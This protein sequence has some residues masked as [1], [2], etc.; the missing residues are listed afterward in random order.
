ML[1]LKIEQDTANT[2]QTSSTDIVAKYGYVLTNNAKLGSGRYG[3]VCEAIHTKTQQKVAI[4]IIDTRKLKWEYRTKFLPREIQSW[5]RFRHPNLVALH[6]VF[7]VNGKIYMPMDLAERG[8]LLTYVQKYG[9]QSECTAKKWMRQ[10][11]SGLC[12]MHM[13]DIAH[14]DLKLEN[15][16]LFNDDTIKIGDFG[17]CRKAIEGEL[18]MTFCG[19]RSYSAPEI[20]LGK[21]YI[22]MKADIWSLGVVAYIIVSNRMPFNEQEGSNSIIIEA[23]RTRAYQYSRRWQLTYDCQNTIDSMMT[24]DFNARPDIHQVKNL[25]WF[26]VP[27]ASKVNQGNGFDK[28][29]V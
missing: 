2:S 23:Q 16:L 29:N 8:D 21:E 7:E 17:F 12:H 28:A 27:K 19:S 9:A 24:F 6:C 25:P 3:K 1:Y 20:L 22:P 5:K 13:R 15:I 14:R 4:K 10:I 18:S 11:I 26:Q